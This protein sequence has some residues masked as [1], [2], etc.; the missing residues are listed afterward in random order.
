MHLHFLNN[1]EQYISISHESKVGILHS[2]A[3]VGTSFC[4]HDF[5]LRGSALRW[6]LAGGSFGFDVI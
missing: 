2:R 6:V 4:L 1:I 3:T 5:G